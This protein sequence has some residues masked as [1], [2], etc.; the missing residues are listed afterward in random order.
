VSVTARG[1]EG[2]ESRRPYYSFLSA[3][4]GER[5]ERGGKGQRLLMI[6]VA[7]RRKG[8]KKRGEKTAAFPFT[9][10]C[11]ERR[12]KN[13]GENFPP[14]HFKKKKKKK[15]KKR[16]G[17]SAYLHGDQGKKGEK[18]KKTAVRPRKKREVLFKSLFSDVEKKEGKGG[19]VLGRL[20]V[21]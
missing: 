7:R 5:E 15:K 6:R 13:P 12:K 17:N 11:A 16:F 14:P 2:E 20:R 8:G 4:K 21:A 19:K 3:E 9:L 18:K 10:R 1:E